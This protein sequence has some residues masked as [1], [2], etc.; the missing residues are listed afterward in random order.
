MFTYQLSVQ[1]PVQDTPP[2]V[3]VVDISVVTDAPLFSVDKNV[4]TGTIFKTPVNRDVPA[5]RC[6]QPQLFIIFCV[7]FFVV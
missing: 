7:F 5:G 3:A 6:V 1:N 2:S 4:T